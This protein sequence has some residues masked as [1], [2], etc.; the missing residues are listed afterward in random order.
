MRKVVVILAVAVSLAL[1]GQSYAQA[2][3]IRA[4]E[5][6]SQVWSQFN[7]GEIGELTVEFREGDE[8][9]VILQ[10]GGDLIETRDNN[11]TFVGVKRSFWVRVAEN[12]VLMSLDG[13]TFKPFS[14]V[15]EGSLTVG[16]SSGH[17]GGPANAVNVLLTAY[18]K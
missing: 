12:Q 4:T 14:S 15:I 1:L 7:R 10:A 5:L 13:S 6:S 8:I 2:K 17:N 9:P 16:A 11:P 3:P 18:L